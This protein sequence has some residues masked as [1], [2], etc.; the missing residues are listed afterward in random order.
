M[1]NNEFVHLELYSKW[2]GMLYLSA[3]CGSNFCQNR[4][5]D[6]AYNIMCKKNEYG[7]LLLVKVEYGIYH[8]IVVI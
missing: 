6:S 5:M 8:G 3:S 4:I 7:A 2:V 1:C